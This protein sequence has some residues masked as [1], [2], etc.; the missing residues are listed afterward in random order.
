ME[1]HE[2][3]YEKV[4][5]LE[6]AVARL[7]LDNEVLQEKLACEEN[8][9]TY[10]DEDVEALKLELEVA[11]TALAEIQCQGVPGETELVVKTKDGIHKPTVEDLRRLCDANG[12][13]VLKKRQYVCAGCGGIRTVD[14]ECEL[15]KLRRQE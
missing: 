9:K 2:R 11:V 10:P 12:L 3:S 6:K 8:T 5:L 14:E 15:C 4:R 7:V 1:S 13:Q